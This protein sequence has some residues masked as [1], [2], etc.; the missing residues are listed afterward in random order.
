MP[1]FLD[2]NG[3]CGHDFKKFFSA[4][5]VLHTSCRLKYVKDQTLNGPMV[6]YPVD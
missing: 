1:F 5:V 6:L 3:L 2:I 4:H